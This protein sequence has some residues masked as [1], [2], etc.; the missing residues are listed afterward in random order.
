[1]ICSISLS[2]SRL[3]DNALGSTLVVVFFDT[4]S[5][6]F[7][8]AVDRSSLIFISAVSVASESDRL[9]SLLISSS[10]SKEPPS[11]SNNSHPSSISASPLLELYRTPS[12][13][14]I[15]ERSSL[16]V[17]GAVDFNNCSQKISIA[18]QQDSLTFY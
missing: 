12:G 13:F 6:L 15:F 4:S 11:A 14:V 3:H 17:A 2:M 18:L 7:E 10:A 9:L 8:P 1:M 5:L 16:I